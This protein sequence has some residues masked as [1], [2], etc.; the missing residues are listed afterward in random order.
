M[1]GSISSSG[2]P[3]SDG[4]IF[5]VD[6][7]FFNSWSRCPFDVV[8]YLGRCFDIKLVVKPGKEIRCFLRTARSRVDFDGL[9]RGPDKYSAISFWFCRVSRLR[10]PSVCAS[11]CSHGYGT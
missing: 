9:K 11:C 6:R 2:S 8:I 3:P 7:R 10:S 4:D 1:G 5:L